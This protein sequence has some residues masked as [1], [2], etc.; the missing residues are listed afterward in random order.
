MPKKTIEP[1]E[2]QPGVT[3]TIRPAPKEEPAVDISQPQV[4]ATKLAFM[5]MIEKYKIQNPAKYALKK[6]EFERKLNSL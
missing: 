2:P 6:E 5:Q 4:S 1:A 3:A